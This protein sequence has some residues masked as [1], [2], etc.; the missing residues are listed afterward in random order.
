MG[1][2]N[3]PAGYGWVTKTLHWLTVLAVAAQFTVGYLM[4]G[5]DSG[6]GRGRGRGR[7]GESG[8]GRGRGGEDSG[9][10]DDPETLLMVH[11]G[12]GLAILV[13]ALLRV[14]WRRVSGLP[15]WSEALS[16]RQRRLVHWTERALLTL[17]FVVPLSGLALVAVGDDDALPLHVAA[18]VAFFVALAAHLS[19]NLRPVILRRML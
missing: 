18:H 6:H 15:P 1:A 7:G 14:G 16:E 5:G 19:T 4:G 11:V 13:I 2:R 10:L 8:R 17:L 9:Y 3:G 12:L